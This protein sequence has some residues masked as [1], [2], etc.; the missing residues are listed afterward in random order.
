LVQVQLIN[1]VRRHALI[2]L[3]DARAV[4]GNRIKL[5][6]FELNILVLS[7]FVA[8]DNIAGINGAVGLGVH[9]PVFDGARRRLRRPGQLSRRTA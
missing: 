3:D 1:L 5:I 4:E 9:F 6:R 7:R 2:D 8:F